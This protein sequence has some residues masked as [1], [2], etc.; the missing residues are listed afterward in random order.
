M[1]SRIERSRQLYERMA[2][3]GDGSGLPI[4]ER[5]LDG[6]EADLALARGRLAHGRFLRDGQEDPQELAFFA[7]AAE[8][9][10]ALDDSRG[11]AEALLWIGIFHQFIRDDDDAA[12]PALHRSRE[13][14][15]QAGDRLGLS[16]ALRHLGIAEHR[17]GRLDTARE[18]LEE[19]TRLRRE[20]DFLPGVAANL[21]GL[22]YIAAAQGRRDD[23]MTAAAEAGRIAGST[24]ALAIARQAEEALI[25]I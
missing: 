4:A 19:S 8:L 9:Y 22:S 6:V 10:E 11:A 25:R 2:F 3:D 13:L 7:R 12:M 20:V 5:E 17:A 24:G 23:A 18:H 14:A 15:E 21:V 1:D 16:Y